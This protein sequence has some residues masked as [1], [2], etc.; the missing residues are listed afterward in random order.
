M[1]LVMRATGRTLADIVLA[2]VMADPDLRPHFDPVL[3]GNHQVSLNTPAEMAVANVQGISLWLYRVI[4]DD[5]RLNAPPTRE[6]RDR[7]RPTPLPLRLF[8][9]VAPVVTIDNANPAVSPELEQ[10]LLGKVMQLFYERPILRGADLRD[11][12]TGTAAEVAVRLETLTLEELARIWN[13]LQRPY[14]LS[15]S[16]EVTIASIVPR[17]APDVVSPVTVAMP[18]Y[19]VI[20]ARE[21][22]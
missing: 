20:V 14:Q 22:A 6:A 5:Q 17:A 15:V 1:Y 11:V 4:R 18:G 13:A 8:Y 3:G 9:L 16:Y 21:P 2:D 19:S 7:L 12:L 10:A